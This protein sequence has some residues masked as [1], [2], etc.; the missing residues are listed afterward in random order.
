MSVG[1]I[2]LPSLFPVAATSLSDLVC[3]FQVAG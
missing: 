3:G 1:A 2:A